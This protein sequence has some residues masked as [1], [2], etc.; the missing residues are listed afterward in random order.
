MTFEEF[1]EHIETIQEFDK[2]ISDLS[3]FGIDLY[4]TK[5][6]GLTYKFQKKYENLVFTEKQ[7]DWI[8]WW[9]Y[10]RPCINGNED[11][12]FNKAFDENGNEIPTN[13]IEDLWNIINNNEL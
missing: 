13:T 4:E 6:P 12:V 1:K 2:F 8:D 3:E 10:E 5:F 7:Q 9:L 11:P